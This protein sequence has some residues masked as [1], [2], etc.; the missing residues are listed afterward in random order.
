[1]GTWELA[2]HKHQAIVHSAAQLQF[3]PQED[4]SDVL[5]AA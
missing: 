3:L 5:D 4:N 1:M 2:K